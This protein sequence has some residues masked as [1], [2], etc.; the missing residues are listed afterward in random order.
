MPP[1]P[2]SLY[3]HVAHSI[4]SL[5]LSYM[6]PGILITFILAFLLKRRYLSPLRRFP[7]PFWASVTRWWLVHQIFRG[8]HE[9]TMLRLH[10]KYGPI[11]RISPFEVA[12]SDPEAIKTIYG[13]TSNFTK[14][15]PKSFCLSVPRPFPHFPALYLRAFCLGFACT[16]DRVTGIYRG[17]TKMPEIPVYSVNG[18]K[19]LMR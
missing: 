6:I 11:I 16:Y 9:K 12:I 17:I 1:K 3:A 5:P 19:E 14:V 4:E 10:A 8:D 7:G 15:L 13:H 18:M 2:D